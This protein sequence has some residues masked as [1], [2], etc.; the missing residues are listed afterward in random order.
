MKVEVAAMHLEGDVL[1]LYGW[2][3]REHEILLW[4][5]LVCV[6]QESYKPPDFQN[7]NEY[8]CFVKQV[9]TM[10]EYRI[11]FARRAARVTDW[12]ENALL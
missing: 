11:E 5:D 4:D 9:G 7:P 12:P 2:V 6:F 1:D 10:A 8:L 3:T